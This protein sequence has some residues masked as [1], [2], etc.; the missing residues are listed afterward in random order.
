MGEVDEIL[1]RGVSRETIEKLHLYA[2]LLTRWTKTI[3][4]VA[5][6]SVANIWDRHVLDSAQIKRL[7]PPQWG[8]WV[9]I[10]SGGGLPGLV[11]AIMDIDRQPITLVESDTRK[12]T[13]LRTVKRELN[14]NIDVRNERIEAVNLIDADVLSA[15]ALAPLNQLIGYADKILAPNGKAFFLK[16]ERYQE[17]L[18]QARNDWH[19]DLE[20]SES[21][22][23]PQARILQISGI[24]RRE[25]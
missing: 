16:G 3:N 2:E 18:D 12:C 1:L 13:F 14:L 6:S 23:Q 4:L 22:T 11:V 9:D 15:R 7:A 8:H 21:L 19:F 17:E 25:H 5:P 20:S 24:R 10:G